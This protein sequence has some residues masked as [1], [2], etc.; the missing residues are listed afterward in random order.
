MASWFNYIPTLLRHE[1]GFANDP[2]DSGGAT[3]KGVTIATFRMWYGADKTV[4]DL[5]AITDCQWCRIMRSYWDGVKGDSI[6]NQSIAELVADWHINSG[7]NAIKRIQRM[8]GITA[9]GIVGKVTLS[10]LNSPNPE[11]TFYRLRG[12]R[13]SYYKDLAQSNPKKRKYLNTWLRRTQSFIYQK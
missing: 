13:E 1:G 12:E 7:V 11:A 4:E 5:K 10:Y 2:D 8:F 3:M 9:D 6:K